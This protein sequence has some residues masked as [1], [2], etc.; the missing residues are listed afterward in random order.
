M[1]TKKQNENVNVQVT[2]EAAANEQQAAVNVQVTNEAA[3]NEQ[4]PNES[5]NVQAVVIDDERVKST[6]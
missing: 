1:K 3:A 5:E 2:N 6:K 4:Q